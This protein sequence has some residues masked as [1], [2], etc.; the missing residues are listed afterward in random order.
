MSYS[1]EE[2]LQLIKWIYSGNSYTE[3]QQLFTV[4][5][6]DRPTPARSTILRVVQ[7]FER[8]G[9][10]MPCRCP[11]NNRRIRPNEET[12]ARDVRICAAVEQ[13]PSLSSRQIS[14][15]LECS[16]DMVKRVLKKHG[17]KSYKIS[18]GHQLLPRDPEARM[19]LC[20]QMT[21]K[22]NADEDFLCF[23]HFGLRIIVCV[24][25]YFLQSCNK[26]YPAFLK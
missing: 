8:T 18:V 17:Y 9:S 14:E 6:E 15:Q 13:N 24:H 4:A 23:V 19:V 16:K 2:K 7:N 21:E 12:E 11:N 20:E 26:V 25:C 22:L 3:T 1:L 10:L 5:F